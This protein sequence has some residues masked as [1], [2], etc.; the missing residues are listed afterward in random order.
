MNILIPARV[1]A[2]LVSGHAA[3]SVPREP[4][5][6]DC[7]R[8]MAG[9]IDPPK[10]SAAAADRIVQGLGR[11]GELTLEAWVKPANTTQAGPARIV[12]L[13]ADPSRRNFTL[14]QA[15]DD[16]EVRFR[17]NTTS[18]N[19]EPSLW[20]S[21]QHTDT[22]PDICALRSA[23]GDLAVLYFAH[24]GQVTLNGTRRIGGMRAEWFNP[25]EG[26]SQ[27]AEP[28]TPNTYHAPDDEDWV[29]L[30]RKP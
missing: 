10:G 3:A 20:S 21:S 30:L 1:D 16:F 9:R 23:A 15:A 27:S 12:T 4:A 19:G 13:S 17:T 24:S 14:G 26:S 11:S 28:I 29:L 2:L 6:G 8:G 22:G 7:S 18:A 5:D 25:R